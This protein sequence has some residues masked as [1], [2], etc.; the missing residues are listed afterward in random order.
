MYYVANVRFTDDTRKGA[1][2]FTREFL[3]EA[4]SITEAEATLTGALREE[5]TVLDYE[6]RGIRASRIDEVYAKQE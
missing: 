3:V 1:K 5:G 4:L 6:V 2:Q